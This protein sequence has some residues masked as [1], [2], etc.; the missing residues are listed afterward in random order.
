MKI[1][2]LVFIALSAV[3]TL[4]FTFVK[5]QSHK[6]PKSNVVEKASSVEPAGGLVSHEAI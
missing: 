5:I 4:S 2:T 1:R 6:E 3:V